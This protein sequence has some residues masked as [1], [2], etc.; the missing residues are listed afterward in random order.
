[1]SNTKNVKLLFVCVGNTCR[2]QMAEAI[3]KDLGHE[4]FSAGTHPGEKIAPNAIKVLSEIGLSVENQFPK[5]TDYIEIH[6]FDKIIS[7][8]CGVN[9]PNLRI[10]QDW[11]LE[12]PYGREIDFYRE[13]RD[14]IFNYLSDL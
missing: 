9:C 3:A 7:M 8:G 14:K 11:N 5:S 1:M 4:A 2:S 6:D 13:T 12:D 10:S